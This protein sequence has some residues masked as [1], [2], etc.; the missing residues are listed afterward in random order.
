MVL[1]NVER[2]VEHKSKPCSRWQ[3]RTPC[4]ASAQAETL[5]GMLTVVRGGRQGQWCATVD[6]DGHRQRIERGLW[7]TALLQAH[8]EHR[9]TTPPPKQ[10]CIERP[11]W[12]VNRRLSYRRRTVGKFS[13]AT[14]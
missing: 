11:W 1:A 4:F 13:V 9:A 2:A 14:L 5:A 12:R 7:L 8:V 10:A 3:R 6:D